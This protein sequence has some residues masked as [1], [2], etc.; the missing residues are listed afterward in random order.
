MFDWLKKV[1]SSK[2]KMTHTIETKVNPFH[3]GGNEPSCLICDRL[4]QSTNRSS[5]ATLA[6]H[7]AGKSCT[8]DVVND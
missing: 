7:Q 4:E 5:K 6:R 3:Y 8:R 2:P 1:L